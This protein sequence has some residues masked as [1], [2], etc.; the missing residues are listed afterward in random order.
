[1]VYTQARSFS[2]NVLGGNAIAGPLKTPILYQIQ[3]KVY[4]FINTLLVCNC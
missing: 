2:E 3:I 4:P 1:M